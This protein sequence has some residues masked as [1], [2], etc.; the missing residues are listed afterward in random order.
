[1]TG[2]ILRDVGFGVLVVCALV[3]TALLVR[4]ELF[5]PAAAGGSSAQRSSVSAWRSYIDPAR[6]EGENDAPVTLVE[7]SDFQCPFCREFAGTVKAARQHFGAK[8]AFEYRHY[9]LTAVHPYARVAAIAAECARRQDRFSAFHD[10]L[11]AG[12]DSMGHWPWATYAHDA[13]VADT[14]RFLHCLAD[15]TTADIVDGDLRAGAALGVRGT[16]TLLVNDQL[17]SGTLPRDQ[18]IAVIDS[19][20]AGRL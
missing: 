12:Q 16:P 11:F 20:L 17:I 4:R 9:P 3:V 6:E 1:M 19:V 13:G 10:A 8:V 15:S 5:T 18:L 14:A 2:K 7:F